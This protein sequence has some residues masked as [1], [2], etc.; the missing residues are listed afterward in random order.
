MKR[1]LIIL[2]LALSE[3]AFCED[4]VFTWTPNPAAE[5]VTGYRMEYIKNPKVT[6]WT[7]L[8]YI[9]ATTNV[10]VVKGIQPGFN[11]KFRIFAVNSFGVGTN[12]S[13]VIT[14]PTN[15]PSVVNDYRLK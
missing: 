10:A 1:T 7:Y 15:T 8:T 5:L 14:I 3:I 4:I 13:N 2:M 11:Y 12:E 6:N 9:P